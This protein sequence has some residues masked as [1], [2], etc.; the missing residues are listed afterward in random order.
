ML[1]SQTSVP[2]LAYILKQISDDKALILLHNIAISGDIYHI[3]LKQMDLTMKQY[4][5]RIS[6]LINAGLIRRTHGKY[7]ITPLGKIVHYVHI[8]IGKAINHYWKMK[9]IESI[10]M[11][12]EGISKTDLSNIIDTLIGDNEIKDV[13]LRALHTS[14]CKQIYDKSH[15][16]NGA[17]F[18]KEIATND[19]KEKPKTHLIAS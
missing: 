1:K 16:E 10:Q 5:S 18:K 4:Y 11:S 15:N 6:G 2:S 12:S 9:A 8:M 13:L 3:S 7:Y 17:S 19:I 14:D